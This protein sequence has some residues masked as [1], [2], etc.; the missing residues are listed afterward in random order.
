MGC[1]WLV[2]NL[3]QQHRL[4]ENAAVFWHLGILL[5]LT[6]GQL[7]AHVKTRAI[8]AGTNDQA[9]YLHETFFIN[10]KSPHTKIASHTRP[11][12]TQQISQ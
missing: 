9:R 4:G 8:G 3:A 7:H 11:H 1:Y 2:G 10:K 12:N 5:E 6:L